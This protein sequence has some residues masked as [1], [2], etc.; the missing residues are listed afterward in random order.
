MTISLARIRRG[1]ALCACAL[2]LVACGDIGGT[3]PTAPEAHV[4]LV[5]ATNQATG[6]EVITPRE[7]VSHL[8]RFFS[9][10]NLRETVFSGDA[11]P[12]LAGS[13]GR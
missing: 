12:R 7:D 1:L 6:V 4:P 13:D 9:P 10:Q 8:R 11:N 5:A 3:R 2:T